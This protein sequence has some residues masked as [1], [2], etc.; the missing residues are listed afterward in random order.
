MVSLKIPSDEK[1]SKRLGGIPFFSFYPEDFTMWP[2]LLDNR[3]PVDG[4][5]VRSLAIRRKW[6]EKVP[7][8]VEDG[9][10]IRL[11]RDAAHQKLALL[12]SINIAK[13]CGPKA[14]FMMRPSKTLTPIDNVALCTGLSP[15]FFEGAIPKTDKDFIIAC[16]EIGHAV[17]IYDTISKGHEMPSNYEQELFADKA[18]L[19]TYLQNGGSIEIVKRIIQLRAMAAFLCTTPAYFLANALANKFLGVPCPED[20]ITARNATAE[21][22]TRV[23]SI[24]YRG[25]ALKGYESDQFDVYI[26]DLEGPNYVNLPND[27][28]KSMIIAVRQD[29]SN[30]PGDKR[31]IFEAAASVANDNSLHPNTRNLASMVM[32]GCAYFTPKLL[33]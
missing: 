23:T 15:D 24:L 32:D 25:E 2:E 17:Q 16:H 33:P 10:L 13:C 5:L 8:L 12:T 3:M 22:Q 7:E 20:F 18:A 26:E 19:R 29:L 11:S 6:K 14:F 1:I 31:R 27:L 4:I 9:G 28:F 30:Y 21:L